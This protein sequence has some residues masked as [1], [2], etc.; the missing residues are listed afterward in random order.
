[1]VGASATQVGVYFM[2]LDFLQHHGLEPIL[3]PEFKI[4]RLESVQEPSEHTSNIFAPPT[5]LGCG[6]LASEG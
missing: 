5:F 1:M 4:A 3:G 2:T 6:V